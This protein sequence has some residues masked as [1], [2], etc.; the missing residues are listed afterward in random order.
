LGSGRP[1]LIVTCSKSASNMSGVVAT[2]M[3][4]G[5][6]EKRQPNVSK[7]DCT[8]FL[9]GP[10][11]WEASPFGGWLLSLL[12]CCTRAGHINTNSRAADATADSCRRR[13]STSN[14]FICTPAQNKARSFRMPAI[15]LF[16]SI[17]LQVSSG[18]TP[19]LWVTTVSDQSP[20]RGV[21]DL[22]VPAL[23]GDAQ[24]VLVGRADTIWRGC[25]RVTALA[26]PGR[27]GIAI[28]TQD[29]FAAKQHTR[30]VQWRRALGK[31]H[32]TKKVAAENAS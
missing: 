25:C 19:R 1:D 28:L 4:Q 32:A 26:Q 29:L 7:K 14:L 20:R 31:H 11:S 27:V 17:I 23:A 15:L 30:S 22:L 21:L 24:H 6:K 12:F 2:Q 3:S 10:I 13:I 8:S 16:W 9:A 18:G 5:K